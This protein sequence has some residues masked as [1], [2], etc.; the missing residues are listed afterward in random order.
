MYQIYRFWQENL[1]RISG[2][3]SLSATLLQTTL[4]H[5]LH[6]LKIRPLKI[7]AMSHTKAR[8]DKLLGKYLDP[9]HVIAAFQTALKW[10]FKN[11]CVVVPENHIAGF[12]TFHVLFL[13]LALLD[14]AVLFTVLRNGV[15]PKLFTALLT[16]LQLDAFF[17]FVLRKLQ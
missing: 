11:F 4:S 6:T 3:L 14:V 5:P 1:W 2:L 9:K 8:I 16:N 12:H 13:L 7:I 17:L 15:P 10:Q